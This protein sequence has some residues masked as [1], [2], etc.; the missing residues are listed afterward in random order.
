MS[1]LPSSFVS[2]QNPK[3]HFLAGSSS[4]PMYQCLLNVSHSNLNST[5]YRRPLVVR[6]GGD[7]PSSASIFVGGF[8]LGGIVVGALGC[9]YAPQKTRKI[10]AEKIAQLNSAIDDVSAQLHADDTPNGAAVASDE[11]EASI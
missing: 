10:L 3:T 1:A 9:V 4:K 5:S 8:V 11:V 2:V 6:A 7:R